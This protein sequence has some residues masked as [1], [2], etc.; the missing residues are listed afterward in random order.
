M[1]TTATNNVTRTKED[2]ENDADVGNLTDDD[3]PS[4][5]HNLKNISE[6]DEDEEDMLGPDDYKE[7]SAGDQMDETG[8]QE[9]TTNVDDDD[10]TEMNYDTGNKTNST[11]PDTDVDSYSGALEAATGN[12]ID[13]SK[14][15][16]KSATTDA[17]AAITRD[18][19]FTPTTTSNDIATPPNTQNRSRVA[20]RTLELVYKLAH[21][22][23]LF[24][25]KWRV[26][27]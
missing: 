7:C 5:N 26:G 18:T 6:M 22:F 12:P 17:S 27:N 13:S 10:D 23:Q 15:S 8:S 1:G 9:R 3:I 21:H 20:A 19:R 2:M 25:S 4:T 14:R 24:I 16:T 11:E